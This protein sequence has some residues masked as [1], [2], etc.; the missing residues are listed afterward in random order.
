M[1]PVTARAERIYLRLSVV[2]FAVLAVVMALTVRDYGITWDEPF[3]HNHGE[4]AFRYYASG[5]RDVPQGAMNLF[6]SSFELPAALFARISPWGEYQSRHVLNAAVGL[7]GIIGAWKVAC[8]VGGGG[9]GFYAALLL[10]LTPCYYGHM[11]NNPKDLPFAVGHIWSLYYLMRFAREFSAPR[12]AL[13]LRLGAAIGLTAGV[14]SGGLVLFGYLFLVWL[15]HS[16]RSG[17]WR[18]GPALLA[19]S[20]GYATMLAFWPYAQRHPLTWPV[21]ALWTFMHFD[22]LSYFQV[23]FKGRIINGSNLPWEYIPRYLLINLP[24]IIL[25]LLAVGAVMAVRSRSGLRKPPGTAGAVA[26]IV[27]SIAF[28]VLL[29]IAFRSPVYSGLRHLLFVVP[30]I[31]CL[32]GL[33]M[34]RLVSWA[35]RRGSAVRWPA[36]ILLFA[37]FSWHLSVMV[38]LH[39][40]QYIYYNALTGGVPGAAGRYDMDYWG[41][42]YP[43]TIKSLA[44]W[45]D[46]RE[47]PRWPMMRYRVFAC[48]ASEAFEAELPD[49]FIFVRDPDRADFHFGVEGYGCRGMDGGKDIVQTERFGVVL[50]YVR[51]CRSSGRRFLGKT[52]S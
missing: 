18:P 23:T 36:V 52:G 34:D 11:F 28:P 47:G 19:A 42:S 35:G 27:F 20:A 22:Q 17:R 30:P 7:L 1:S 26:L 13:L 33:V 6:G 44:R 4:L 10:A 21:E 8:L 48:G 12:L 14:R 2:L 41:N 5:M 24:E 31:A 38:R 39:P 37:Y 15:V 45:L 9:A 3:H 50:S 29:V 32:A 49:S 40:Q 51:D 43:E 25:V 46:E 16:A